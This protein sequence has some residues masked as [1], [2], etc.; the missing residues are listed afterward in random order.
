MLA[1]AQGVVESAGYDG[2]DGYAVSISH[3]S[4]MLTRYCHMQDVEVQQGRRWKPA[5]ASAPWARP[6]TARGLTCTF[7]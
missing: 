3:G 2:E 6:A 5:S 7:P 4:G 1:A